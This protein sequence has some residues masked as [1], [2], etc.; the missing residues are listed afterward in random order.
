MLVIPGRKRRPRGMKRKL[1]LFGHIA[2]MY[3]KRKIKIVM[4]EE[5]EGT[6]RRPRRGR[7]CRE[8][9]DDIKEWC[10]KYIGYLRRVAQD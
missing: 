4:L 10:E 6:N 5:M 1:T 8:W 7:R 9:L 3:D 2:R